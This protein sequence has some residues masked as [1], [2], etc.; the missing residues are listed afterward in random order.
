MKTIKA[1]KAYLYLKKEY[2]KS[3]EENLKKIIGKKPIFLFQKPGGYL[4]GEETS[5]CEVIE[6]RFPEPRVKPPFPAESGLWGYPTLINNVETLF[7]V[8][9][10]N[11]KEYK[12]KRG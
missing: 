9:Q 2:F 6:G 5:V 3:F 12:N 7:R 8:S 1:D 10:I 11:R 4:A